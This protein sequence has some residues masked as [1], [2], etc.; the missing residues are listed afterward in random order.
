[1]SWK[2]DL[3]FNLILHIYPVGTPFFTSTQSFNAL[4]GRSGGEWSGG[5]A[6]LVVSGI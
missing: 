3:P 4:V 6:D 1:M 5:K 2:K